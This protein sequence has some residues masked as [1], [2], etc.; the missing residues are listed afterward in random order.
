MIILWKPCLWKVEY[1][2]AIHLI[3]YKDEI[4][5]YNISQK[6]LYKVITVKENNVLVNHIEIVSWIMGDIRI[7]T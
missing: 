1:I 2:R 4:D 6:L 7:D 5:K 3:L